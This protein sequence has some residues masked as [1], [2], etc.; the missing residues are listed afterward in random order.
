VRHERGGGDREGARLVSRETCKDPSP[1]PAPWQTLCVFI[2]LGRARRGSS[3]PALGAPTRTAGAAGAS[4]SA[5]PPKMRCLAARIASRLVRGTSSAYIS[6]HPNPVCRSWREKGL[7][8]AARSEG[9]PPPVPPPVPP[10]PPSPPP[11]AAWTAPEMRDYWMARVARCSSG[12][13]HEVLDR[14]DWSN[15]LGLAMPWSPPFPGGA[16]SF[17]GGDRDEEN[18]SDAS[19]SSDGSGTAGGAPA[20]PGAPVGW[21]RGR[22][23]ARWARASVPLEADYF[24]WKGEDP[25]KVLL[26]QVGKFFEAVGVDAVM[27][28]EHGGVQPMGRNKVRAGF[29]CADYRRYVRSLVAAGLS[30]KLYVQESADHGVARVAPG[31]GTLSRR[32]LPPVT[33]ASPVVPSAGLALEG[34]GGPGTDD[35]D[36]SAYAPPDPLEDDAFAALSTSVVLGVAWGG[37]ASA[38]MGRGGGGGFTLSEVDLEG[39]TWSSRPL[40]SEDALRVRLERGGVS[41]VYLAARAADATGGRE[42][43]DRRTSLAGADR[44]WPWRARRAAKAAGVPVSPRSYAPLRLTDDSPFLPFLEQETSSSPSP[45]PEGQLRRLPPDVA[46]L[47]ATLL[48]EHDRPASDLANFRPVGWGGSGDA[49]V[50]SWGR[51]PR[52]LYLSTAAALGVSP[53]AHGSVPRRGR[54]NNDLS[55]RSPDRDERSLLCS[56]ALSEPSNSLRQL[57]CTVM[58]TPVTLALAVS[59]TGASLRAPAEGWAGRGWPA[60]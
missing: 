22:S 24:R 51:K 40:Q 45:A 13:V 37:G 25:D 28:I 42:G 3:S 26:V 34:D 59:S 4:L 6:I 60:P 8:A 16:L 35:D 52:A 50:P 47:V 49:Q 19:S 39:G 36:A 11:E 44:T 29:P 5:A 1:S 15:R 38:A 17:E 46:G 31:K 56:V 58:S 27:L 30:V 48:E 7:A 43:R 32:P 12:S 33:P 53:S 10:A 21:A 54:W 20:P 55:S 9:R 23:V 14:L 2:Q 41:A 18:I 57:A